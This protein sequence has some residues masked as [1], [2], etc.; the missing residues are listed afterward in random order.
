MISG[1]W[2]R[3]FRVNAGLV[4]FM[5][6]GASTDIQ[7]PGII[8][9][10]INDYLGQHEVKLGSFHQLQK[11]DPTATNKINQI[12]FHTGRSVALVV[13]NQLAG[14]FILQDRVRS[15]SAAALAELQARGI[16]PV[17]ALMTHQR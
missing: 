9:D 8:D 10:A 7:N 13:D 14:V 3:D 1:W 17:M 2:A 11:L 12:D 4:N 5:T 6:A 16:K 15:D